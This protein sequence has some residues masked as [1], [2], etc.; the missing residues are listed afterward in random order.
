MSAGKYVIRCQ[1]C[2][3]GRSVDHQ[4]L[5]H[6]SQH[7]GIRPNTQDDLLRL[8]NRLRCSSCGQPGQLLWQQDGKEWKAVRI[9]GAGECAICG[10]VVRR[11]INVYRSRD[12]LTRHR[13]CDPESFRYY[14]SG[15]G[16]YKE[17]FHKSSCGWVARLDKSNMLV[18]AS[19][20]QAEFSGLRPWFLYRPSGR[21]RHLLV[22]ACSPLGCRHIASPLVPVDAPGWRRGFC[23]PTESSSALPRGP[24]GGWRGGSS[25]PAHPAASELGPGR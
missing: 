6:L 24:V 9:Q 22:P 16:R 3:R 14:A 18:F 17:A 8:I 5:S 1:A 12:G 20:K 2:G 7:T 10:K 25:A 23:R 11:G 13:R 21:N 4:L 19:K 15:V